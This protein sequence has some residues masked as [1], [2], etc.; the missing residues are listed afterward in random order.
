MA[1]EEDLEPPTAQEPAAEPDV[2]QQGTVSSTDIT[3][4][5][6][7]LEKL[8]EERIGDQ[9]RLELWQQKLTQTMVA[10]SASQ[11]QI[12]R[13]QQQQHSCLEGMTLVLKNL[14]TVQVQ[15]NV[16]T[17]VIKTSLDQL[18]T[19]QKKMDSNI[20]EMKDHLKLAMSPVEL[21]PPYECQWSEHS[22]D[23]LDFAPSSVEEQGAA[24]EEKRAA[25]EEKRAA[26]EE[27]RA[28]DEEKWAVK[29][30]KWAAGEQHQPA[31]EQHQTD[32]EQQ[33]PAEEEKQ[34]PSKRTVRPRRARKDKK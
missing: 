11:R 6:A 31:K 26:E 17:D 5:L 24:E 29:E 28:A 25:E 13:T 30:E 10:M 9:K 14:T 34:Q 21:Q 2:T 12:Q 23:K 19:A 8:K 7:K 15:S 16:S 32:E 22:A 3:K 33:Q 27:K 1:E 18:K 4:I 20:A